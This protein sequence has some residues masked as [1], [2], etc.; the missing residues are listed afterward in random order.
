MTRQDREKLTR[1][2]VLFLALFYDGAFHTETFNKYFGLKQTDNKTLERYKHDF[3]ACFVDD[4]Y[5][6]INRQKQFNCGDDYIMQYRCEN[7]V[8]LKRAPSP[9]NQTRE[10]LLQMLWLFDNL[11]FPYFYLFFIEKDDRDYEDIEGIE[12]IG[13]NLDVMKIGYDAVMRIYGEK[14]I[15]GDLLDKDTT[16]T[17]LSII[18]DAIDIAIKL[19]IGAN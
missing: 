5:V 10:F 16:E 18:Y 2:M 15:L 6:H 9:A 19:E 1:E 4:I 11:L 7:D 3:N 8:Y 12:Y 14:N 13:E 17:Y